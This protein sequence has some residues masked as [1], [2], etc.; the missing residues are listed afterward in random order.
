MAF[1]IIFSLQIKLLDTY[2]VV[3]FDGLIYIVCIRI[4]I[5]GLLLKFT[6]TPRT[7]FVINVLLSFRAIIRH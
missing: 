4:R 6:F 7:I 1:S 2:F 5:R 3:L